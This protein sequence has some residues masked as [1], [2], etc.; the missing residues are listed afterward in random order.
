MAKGRRGCGCALVVFV[1]FMGVLAALGWKF[2]L[3]WWKK[4]PPPA[5]GGEL[6]V[7]VL[8]VGQGDSIL[9]IAPDGKTALV[10]MGDVGKGKTVLAALKANNVQQIDYLIATHSHPDHIGG[11]TEIFNGGV[12]VLTVIDSGIPPPDMPEAE[13]AASRRRAPPKKKQQGSN[14]VLPSTKAYQDFLSAVQQSGAQYVKAEPDQH[15]DLGGGARLTVLAPMQPTFTR[16]QLLRAGGNEPNANSVVMRLDYGDFSML[17]PGDAESVTEDRLLN[18]DVDVTA[19]ILKVA[20]HG[21]KYAT[22]EN[23]LNRVKPEVAIISDGEFNVYSHPAQ[24]VLDRLK[25]AGVKVYR[26]DLQGEIIITTKGKGYEIKAAHDAKSDVFTGR[27]GRKDDS[28]RSGFIAY[29]E[30]GPPPRRQTRR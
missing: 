28:T 14:A 18:H 30:F 9:I 27:E 24:V 16:E 22:S 23:F 11:A 8:D 7:H 15:Y 25:A 19:K 13:A 17:L 12:K 1:L 10:D 26:T 21:S 6:Q 20:H 3:P 2:V 29:G 5:S 4:K